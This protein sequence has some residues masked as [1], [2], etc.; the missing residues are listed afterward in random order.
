MIKLTNT[1]LRAVLQCTLFFSVIIFCS[2]TNSSKNNSSPKGEKD[3]QNNQI[4]TISLLFIGDIMGHVPQIEAAF[5]E[6]S[7]TY[8]Y[9]EVFMNVA[10]F[11]N[12][13]DFSIGNLELTLA[14]KPYSGYPQFSSP[15]A[16][17]IDCKKFGIDAFVTANNHSCD[18]GIKGITRTISVLDS[19]RIKHTGT[20]INH[21]E[22]SQKNLLVLEKNNIR[23]G[24]L[25]YTYGTNGIPIPKPAIVNLIDR[26]QMLKDIENSKKENLDKLIIVLHWGLEYES[27][28]NSFQT[29]LADFLFEHGVDIIIG[30]HPHVLQKMEYFGENSSK[31]ERLIAYS[32]GNFISNQRNRKSDGGAMFQFS[33]VKQNGKTKIFNPGYRLIWVNKPMI[34]GK[35]KFQLIPCALAEKE[36]YKGITDESKKAMKIFITDSRN[37]FNSQNKAVDE[38]K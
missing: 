2:C 16:I 36:N 29:E 18:R 31:K 3:A 34:K 17:A 9:K 20:F 23:L 32:L 21:T 24:I 26:N 37:L 7:N 22:K 25:N 30:A 12:Q 4:D 6:K 28:P 5:D 1:F 33:L 14:G 15:D 10:P 13:V 19:L 8:D 35:N 11:F 27:S 38:L